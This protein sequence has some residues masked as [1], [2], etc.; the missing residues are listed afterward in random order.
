M[1]KTIEWTKESYAKTAT[2]EVWW[3]TP[4]DK[5]DP[6]YWDAVSR[7]EEIREI[8]AMEQALP[9]VPDW[10]RSVG[11][12]Y[13]PPCGVYNFPDA[14][15]QVVQLIGASDPA[16]ISETFKFQCYTADPER[17]RVAQDYC[18][19]LDAWLAGVDPGAPATEL[20][21]LS[22]RKIAWSA[23]CSDLWRIMGD[24]TEMKELQVELIL[25]AIR[26]AIKQHRWADD[27]GAVF[28]RD[29]FLG[30]FEP[31]ED[32]VTYGFHLGSARATKI[33]ARIKALDPSWEWGKISRVDWGTWWLCGPKA[34][35]FLEYDLWAI[36]KGRPTEKGEEVPGFLRCEDT[37]PNQDEAAEWYG[38][39]CDALDAWWKGKDPDG[40]VG[41]DVGRRLWD[42]TPVKQWLVRLYLKKLRAYEETSGIL[43]SLVHPGPHQKR[44]TKRMELSP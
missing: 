23:V 15:M 25:N 12:D 44:G 31:H 9:E 27:G 39:F 19:C 24:R 30:E 42:S 16:F 1:P 4:C 2:S 33:V 8:V 6:T 29:Q 26:H 18:L 43:N 3:F 32:H 28:C 41:E 7:D 37:Y 11:I 10:V 5:D 20:N 35:R 17:K 22:P 21:A 34:F 13:L 40:R 36:A 14:L 38:Q